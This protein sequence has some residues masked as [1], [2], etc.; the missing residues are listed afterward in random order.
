MFTPIA[1]L[2]LILLAFRASLMRAESNR[3]LAE[4]HLRPS[5]KTGR[6]WPAMRVLQ[7]L[8]SD[9]AVL[10]PQCPPHWLITL[11]KGFATTCAVQLAGADIQ[12]PA[13][14]GAVESVVNKM[15]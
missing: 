9:K 2:F 6:D 5:G 13:L 15:L 4:R 7:A 8:L 12:D 14:Q 3:S 11:R 10:R 1:A